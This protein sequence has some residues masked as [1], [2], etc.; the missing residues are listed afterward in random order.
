MRPRDRVVSRPVP[1]PPA[2]QIRSSCGPPEPRGSIS[3]TT[4]KFLIYTEISRYGPFICQRIK[5]QILQ[6]RL[7]S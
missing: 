6:E 5:I 2:K 1:G 7:F 3:R 4:R